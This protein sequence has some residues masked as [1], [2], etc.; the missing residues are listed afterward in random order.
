MQQVCAQYSVK[1][2]STPNYVLFWGYHMMLS[3]RNYR[4]E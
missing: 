4:V 1:Y 2:F 3:L